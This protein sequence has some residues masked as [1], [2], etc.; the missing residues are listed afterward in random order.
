MTEGAKGTRYTKDGRRRAPQHLIGS[1][2][3][4][5]FPWIRAGLGVAF[6]TA[7][8]VTV[9]RRSN[10]VTPQDQFMKKIKVQPYGVMGNQMSLT[11]T[12]KQETHAPDEATAITDPAD[13]SVL[14]SSASKGV[15]TSG[16]IYKWLG[17][18]GR[19]PADVL[20]AISKYCDAVY[21]QY[22][23]GEAR[24]PCRQPRLQG[25]GV[26]G[27]GCHHRALPCLS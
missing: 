19:F 10:Q 24:D 26:V 18:T 1:G 7:F 21:H 12:L 14:L 22:P 16:A 8:V 4:K 2:Y 11:G 3:V 25:R 13:L 5:P 17:L 20:L 23:G 27:A 6:M 9:Y 15:G